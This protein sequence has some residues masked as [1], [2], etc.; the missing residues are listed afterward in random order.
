MFS[1]G[2]LQH[3]QELLSEKG[4]V[5]VRQLACKGLLCP[6]AAAA[7]LS[8]RRRPGWRKA[9]KSRGQGNKQEICLSRVSWQAVDVAV[10]PQQSLCFGGI[11]MGQWSEVGGGAWAAPCLFHWRN[12][13]WLPLDEFPHPGRAGLSSR[14][15]KANEKQKP[16]VR[17]AKETDGAGSLV[18]ARQAESCFSGQALI[19]SGGACTRL[20]SQ[21]RGPRVSPRVSA[22]PLCLWKW[23]SCFVLTPNSE[24]TILFPSTLLP[25]LLS[26]SYNEAI[27]HDD[28]ILESICIIHFFLLMRFVALLIS[29]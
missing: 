5:F 7:G 6:Q 23:Q 25:P 8:G 4:G 27:I 17:V 2:N 19:T 24:G 9:K 11:L 10:P 26:S 18:C 14:F 22:E 13:L 28:K 29:S 20:R 1:S 16:Q 12:L 3:W 15:P 21:P